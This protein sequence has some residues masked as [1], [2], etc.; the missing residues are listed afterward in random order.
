V[1]LTAF[2]TTQL[3]KEAEKEGVTEIFEKP[4]N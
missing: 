1:I 3:K 4:I 2:K